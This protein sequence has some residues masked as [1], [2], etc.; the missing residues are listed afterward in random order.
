MP[1]LLD[2][3]ILVEAEAFDDFGG[4]VLDSQFELQMGSPYLLAHGNGRPVADATTTISIPDGGEYNVWVRTKDWVPSYHPGRFNLLVNG[5]ALDTEFGAND[6]DWNWQPGGSVTLATGATKLALHDLTGFCG[7]CDAIF[8]SR[9]DKAPPEKVDSVE[10]AWRRRLRGI[11]SEPENAGIFDVVVVGGGVPGIAAALTAARLGDRVALV[12]DRPY[13]GGNASVEIGLRPRGV[14][15][16]LVDEISKRTT[17]G[18]LYAKQLLDREPNATVFLEHTVYSTV[19]AGSSIVSVNARHARSG[20]EI[21][22]SAPIFIDCSGKAILGLYS[23]A[24]T[25]FGQESKAEYRESLAPAQGDNSHHGNTVFFRTRMADSPVAFPSVPW[26]T[27]VAKDFSNLGGQLEKPGVE[28]APGPLVVSPR[29]TPDSA[30]QPRMKMPLTH[31]WEY[32]QSL[33]PYTQ[34]EQ[35]RDYLL[36][37]IYG[38]FSNVKTMEPQTYANLEFDWV[39]YVA[40]QGEFRRYKGDYILTETDIRD[41]KAFPDAVVQN[42]GAFCLHYPG[43]ETY[44]FRLKYWEWDER[45]GKP[46]DIPFR[47][48]YSTNISNL[49]MAGKH[50]SVTHIA[51]S[52]TKFMGNGAQH[53]IA[54][55]AAAHLC[56]KY[57]TTPQDVCAKHMA[58]LRTISTAVSEAKIGRSH[59]KAN[60]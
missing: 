34:A 20:R 31:F 21:S 52:N 28:N 56:K 14:T 55:A 38:T 44:D 10:R 60:L 58:E 48:L 19:T 1:T 37:A 29:Q 26:A 39:A 22:L 47:C 2:L 3:G 15:G 53:A 42:G 40:A 7:R 59:L 5:I 54:T 35:I 36:R 6:R 57:K 13:L 27:K 16:P 33:D 50:I 46:Y 41:H 25:L 49:M 8:L 51:G 4:W 23:G 32:G 11:P 45:D 18:D 17:D 9:D 24:E 12:Q 30:V 43:N